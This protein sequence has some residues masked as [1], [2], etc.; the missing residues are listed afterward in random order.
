MPFT[1]TI[2]ERG[3]SWAG[4]AAIKSSH[5]TREDAEAELTRYVRANWDAEVG[6]DSPLPDDHAVMV[7]EYFAEVLEAYDISERAE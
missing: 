4:R 1:L 7:R 2:E 5:S 3:H 6:D